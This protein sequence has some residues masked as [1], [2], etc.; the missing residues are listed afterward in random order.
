M[1]SRK[2]RGRKL[3]LNQLEGRGLRALKISLMRKKTT[4]R[5]KP[6][7]DASTT[8]LTFYFSRFGKDLCRVRRGGFG[9]DPR[10]VKIHTTTPAGFGPYFAGFQSL[11][12]ELLGRG[13]LELT[14]SA[15]NKE[16]ASW[17]A[18]VLRPFLRG[19]QSDTKFRRG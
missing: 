14:V 10:P 13:W 17:S 4:E 1:T 5:K 11:C 18:W 19:L 8:E 16:S 2:S 9:V 3:R 6:A 7:T 12:S 15:G